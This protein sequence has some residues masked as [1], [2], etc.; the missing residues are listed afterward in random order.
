[1]INDFYEIKNNKNEIF[2]EVYISLN[3]IPENFIDRNIC[4]EDIEL[5]QNLV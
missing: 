4:C 3:Y 5:D 1:M 2:G